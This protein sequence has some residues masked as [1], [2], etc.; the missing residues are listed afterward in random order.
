MKAQRFCT[1]DDCGCTTINGFHTTMETKHGST[2]F[3]SSLYDQYFVET[4]E[5][6][7]R[8]IHLLVRGKRQQKYEPSLLRPIYIYS[9]LS[10][11][12]SAKLF[13]VSVV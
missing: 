2:N 5:A 12:Y 9:N 10:V 1:V 4:D 3:K 7:G 13:V 11:V 6:V 8:I